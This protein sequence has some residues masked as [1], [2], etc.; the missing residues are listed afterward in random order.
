VLTP[1]TSH[2]RVYIPGVDRTKVRR[3]FEGMDDTQWE[4][5]EPGMNDEKECLAKEVIPVFPDDPKA[6]FLADLKTEGQLATTTVKQFWELMEFR[7][8][9]SSGRLVGFLSVSVKGEKVSGE[10]DG[11][12]VDEKTFTRAWEMLLNG[13]YS[14][15]E[16]AGNA[17]RKWLD[18]VETILPA[19]TKGKWG[20][21]LV[22]NGRDTRIEGK[23]PAE[24]AKPVNILGGMHIRKKKKN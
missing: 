23:R 22:P 2:G 11:V 17:T 5:C 6:R 14:S 7:Q 16:V 4:C 20:F 21:T 3:Y 19:E 9:C 15:D 1:V 24:E 8:E 18:V 12:A 10:A 13:E